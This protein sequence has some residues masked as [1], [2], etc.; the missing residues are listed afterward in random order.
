MARDPSAQRV[1][2]RLRDPSDDAPSARLAA[3]LVD[4][5]LAR[6]V[7]ELV[8]PSTVVAVLRDGLK[9]WASAGPGP[10]YVQAQLE[11]ARTALAASPAP[12]AQAV[13]EPLREGLRTF[14]QLHWAAR[15]EVVLKVLDR[16]A[17]RAALRAQLAQTLA[18]FGRKAA[19]PV[20]DNAIA[21][22]L[23]GLGKLA[24]QIARPSPL[25]AIASAVSGEVERQVE[26]RASDFADG[27]VAGVLAGIAE[28][29]SDPTQAAQQA[30]LRLEVL[31]GIL[32]LTGAEAAELAGG[33]IASQVAIAREALAAW[34]AH[35]D[36][37]R[38]V[39]API[40]WL[41]AREGDR[42]VGALLDALG[43]K[44]TVAAHACAVV[45]GT[46][47]RVTAGG[48]FEAWLDALLA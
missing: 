17:F 18:D 24:G 13:P 28:H 8:E 3:L 42:P 34:A 6:P 20:A 15:R 43:L 30:A 19:S 31:D 5:V 45:R 1:L 22:G 11:G 47:G 40:A 21:R 16:P 26:K 9:A 33:T 14:A 44:A 10:D 29:V 39:E 46:I 27:A 38:D 35:P 12:L 7:R 41:V 2:D 36:F 23:G 48:A 4:E 25:G 32:S 37:A